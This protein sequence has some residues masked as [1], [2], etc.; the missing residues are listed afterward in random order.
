MIR[1]YR[2]LPSYLPKKSFY[3]FFVLDT[4]AEIAL[5]PNPIVNIT[6]QSVQPVE[7]KMKIPFIPVKTAGII[8]N[9]MNLH[10]TLIP[11]GYGRIPLHSPMVFQRPLHPYTH[12][13]IFRRPVPYRRPPQGHMHHQYAAAASTQHNYIIKK[14]F[15]RPPPQ[16]PLMMAPQY[17]R[18]MVKPRIPMQHAATSIKTFHFTLA[19]HNLP[20]KLRKVPSST[21]TTTTTTT[22]SPPPPTQPTKVTPADI[23]P[24]PPILP[25]D[26]I[27]L[28]AQDTLN[29]P[30][31]VNTGFN[32]HSVVVEGGFK[33]IIASKISEPTAQDRSSIVDEN[34][35]EE[36]VITKNEDVEN[37]SKEVPDEIVDKTEESI[38][39]DLASEIVSAIAEDERKEN[40]FQG[41]Q[42]ETFE[43]MFIPSPPDR[44]NGS[45]TKKPLPD[46]GLA[47][48]ISPLHHRN[49]PQT[50]R[51]N[52]HQYSIIRPRPGLVRRPLYPNNIIP[53]FRIRGSPTFRYQQNEEA[54][55]DEM[56]MAADR[57][58]SYYLPP[59]DTSVSPGVVVTYDGK[60]VTD[61]GLAAP[62]GIKSTRVPMG[63]ADF[64]RGT[65]QFVPYRGEI[66]PPVPDV[67]SPENIP[68]L[69]KQNQQLAHSLPEQFKHQNDAFPDPPPIKS[70]QL[71]LVQSDELNYE[72]SEIKEVTALNKTNKTKKHA[73]K[74]TSNSK[75]D[76]EE[77][78]STVDDRWPFLTKEENVNEEENKNPTT[79][80]K[81]S[82]TVTESNANNK[83]E[84]RSAHH[85]PE[86]EEH[87]NPTTEIK[88]STTVTESNANNKRER[89][90]AHHEPDHEEHNYKH[91]EHDRSQNEARSAAETYNMISSVILSTALIVTFYL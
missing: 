86:H 43:P 80:I 39:A 9:K 85:E 6:E 90:S 75:E 25:S 24:S 84:R 35:E 14:P 3:I 47:P 73:V 2:T 79:E 69:R 71:A 45:N 31:A 16:R 51:K 15:Y 8:P 38:I 44:R 41:Q 33:P 21:S 50:N 78:M 77:M 27:V 17:H 66:P 28:N 40:P 68:Q 37:P 30:V 56:A 49:S 4:Q 11:Q 81:Y 12:A 53:P 34:D 32:P 18:P 58:D 65:P 54:L 57:M 5:T 20:L 60:S 10:T 26:V 67:I 61:A 83:R 87:K 76:E 22:T 7:I 48:P 88:D 72:G 23:K 70:T 42:P 63:T 55:E 29:I 52:V 36:E 64:I 59:G 62:L 19:P 13:P 89:R 46:E 82:T 1:Q 91:K 74:K